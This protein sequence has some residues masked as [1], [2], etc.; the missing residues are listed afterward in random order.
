MKVDDMVFGFN[1]VRFEDLVSQTAIQTNE[2]SIPYSFPDV[3]S[4]SPEEI[5]MN[6][7]MLTDLRFPLPF[8]Y[9]LE[10]MFFNVLITSYRNR[11][12]KFSPNTVAAI[13]AE[14]RIIDSH[15]QLLGN[16]ASAA[17]TGLA[18]LGYSGCGKS[19]SLEVLIRHT[20]GPR[21]ERLLMLMQDAIT[22]NAMNPELDV[23]LYFDEQQQTAFSQEYLES[24]KDADRLRENV[25]RN[26]A[27]IAG[28]SYNLS[29]VSD[30]YSKVIARSK[31]KKEEQALTKAVMKMLKRCP[32]TSKKKV[33]TPVPLEEM[34]AYL[35]N[36]TSETKKDAST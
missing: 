15:H 30:A 6:L 23:D 1:D 16:P 31:Q 11:K 27:A 20:V 13:H 34:R 18:L 24:C 2:D 26:I 22:Q 36:S 3:K 28:S 5:R 21:M 25:F 35:L 32:A 12:S 17:N 14:D 29:A 19:S 4:L 7:N 9:E 10:Q 33:L 8:H